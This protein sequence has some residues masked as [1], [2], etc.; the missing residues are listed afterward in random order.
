VAG[1]N[2]TPLILARELFHL[3]GTSGHDPPRCSRRAG[4]S[5]ERLGIANA[6]RAI[7]LSLILVWTCSAFRSGRAER[8]L[9][10]WTG[11]QARKNPDFLAVVGFEESSTQADF[12][13]ML[14]LIRLGQ[15]T[16]GSESGT[17]LLSK[18]DGLA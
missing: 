1:E 12:R 6:V 3:Q 18:S 15:N 9:Y 11:D 16:R 7:A 2:V 10:V 17:E 4:G 8:Y 13:C 14:Q 5:G